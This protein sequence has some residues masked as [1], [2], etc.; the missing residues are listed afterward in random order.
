MCVHVLER[1]PEKEN[2]K[3]KTEKREREKRRGKEKMT[4]R[5]ERKHLGPLP[6]MNVHN[7]PHILDRT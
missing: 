6:E 7:F 1:E 4:P 3:A 5:T 2:R